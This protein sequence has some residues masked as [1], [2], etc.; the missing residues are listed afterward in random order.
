MNLV[1]QKTLPEL[2][3]AINQEIQ[4]I[5]AQELLP[6][7]QVLYEIMQYHMGWDESSNGGESG[8][9][10]L[11]PLFLL[12]S[13]QAAGGSWE[14]SL[15]AA[16]AVELLHNFS[17]IHDDIQD[18]SPLRHGRPSVWK[19]WNPALAIN[20]G[21]TMF[22]LANL[23]LLELEK[24]TNPKVILAAHRVFCQTC[25]NL[26]HGQHLDISNEIKDEIK[27]AE[28]LTM[29][30]GKTAALVGACMQIGAI[31]AGSDPRTQELV[32]KFGE[33]IGMAFQVIDDI[34]G[35]WGETALTGK[36]VD[37]DLIS[38]KLTIPI[39]FGIKQNKEFTR[40]WRKGGFIIE[41][42]PDLANLLQ[43]EG[44]RSFSEQMARQYT[45]SA[46][47]IFDQIGF[48]N[49]AGKQLKELCA[50]LISRNY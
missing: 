4:R 40:R 28:Y 34:L 45:E 30:N 43:A 33:A 38:R 41:D 18:Q 9:K 5:L 16:A 13:A 39:L 15:P 32:Y 42:V 44:A 47:E 37:G 22:S 24:T 48:N 17:L 2:K 21:D 6:D 27:I 20:A 29:I 19:K 11:R 23:A 36:S 50:H 3:V 8:G 7:Y 46:M 31:T 49:E 35:I 25:V 10:R 1:T 12:L 26:T 14:D